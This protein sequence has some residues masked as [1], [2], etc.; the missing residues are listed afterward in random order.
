MRAIESDARR[1]TWGA[2]LVDAQPALSV[3]L[4]TDELATIARGLAALRA[5]TARDKLE[6]V[7][8]SLAAEPLGAGSAD[9]SAFA[10]HQVVEPGTTIS[11][12]AG[13][14]LGVRAAR[15]PYIHVGETHAFPHPDWAARIID[16]LSE[17]WTVVVSGL[18]N[19]NPEG[20]ISW[21]NLLIDYA[22]WLADV[23]AG[24]IARTPPY[25]AAFE[26]GF[27]RSAVDLSGDVFSPGYDLTAL[28]R[29]R[30]GRILFV[31]TAK[32]EHV[33]VSLASY[34]LA[35]RYTVARARAGFRSRSWSWARRAVYVATAPL[36]PVVL[37]ARLARPARATMRARRLPALTL[38]AILVGLVA[39]VC[40]EVAAFVSGPSAAVERRAELMEIHKL[41]YTRMR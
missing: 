17:Q 35:Q 16:S 33:N 29:S 27:A 1:R 6:L 10:C 28:V 21:A 25:N 14:A 34:W 13:R 26:V 31:P 23:T 7:L 37:A 20:A 2:R 12:A 9:L 30:R 40:G 22:P 15:A 39:S 24:E 19:A 41:R 8:V 3:V 4:A 32:V 5:Q 38:P 36:I 18:V 11:L